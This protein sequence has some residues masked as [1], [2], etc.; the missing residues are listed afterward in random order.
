VGRAEPHGHVLRQHALEVARDRRGPLL[1]L[2]EQVVDMALRPPREEHL[3]VGAVLARDP[4][5]GDEVLDAL[6]GADPAEEEHARAVGAGAELRPRLVLREG[7]TVDAVV[8][9]VRDLD[10]LL[11]RDLVL[12]RRELGRVRRD[13]VDDVGVPHKALVQPHG[14]P[15]EA[16]VMRQHVVQREDDLAPP[17]LG[18]EERVEEKRDAPRRGLRRLRPPGHGARPLHVHHAAPR[19]RGELHHRVEE[20][21]APSELIAAGHDLRLQQLHVGVVV[22]PREVEDTAISGRGGHVGILSS[23]L[24]R[25][26]D[27]A[28]ESDSAISAFSEGRPFQDGYTAR[29]TSADLRTEAPVI[30]SRT[31]W[32]DVF[33]GTVPDD[34]QP[35][36]SVS[37]IIPAYKSKTLE[38]TLASL[39]AQDYPEDLM[40]VVVL[41]DGGGEEP[42]V[43]G[44][45]AP[46]NTRLIR[47]H[48]VSD[49]WGRSNATDIGIK[50]TTG[51]IIYWCD[52]DMILFRD[53]VRQ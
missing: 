28:C 32:R 24:P 6:V 50:A 41:D 16:R 8:A 52:S 51:D 29:V 25:C 33:D 34:W 15:L 27:G 47:I 38:F 12:L 46:K 13:R 53:N 40:E 21:G 20:I 1:E 35:T 4:R 37:V 14:L 44:E 7:G 17:L 39:A 49:G 42:V 45:Y 2:V 19:G 18:A 9:R 22:P 36:M 11:G 5:R 3:D 23:A 26:P 48:E 10:D 30:V 31:R 43:I